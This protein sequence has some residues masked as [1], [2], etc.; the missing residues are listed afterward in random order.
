MSLFLIINLGSVLHLEIHTSAD[1]VS[2]QKSD[3]KMR[4]LNRRYMKLTAKAILEIYTIENIMVAQVTS[5]TK[6]FEGLKID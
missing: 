2:F 6:D 3:R 1:H 5:L 4:N